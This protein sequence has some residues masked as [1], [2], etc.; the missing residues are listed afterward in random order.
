MISKRWKTISNTG[1]T[2]NIQ[3]M[4]KMLSDFRAF[5]QNDSCRLTDFWNQYWNQQSEE[6]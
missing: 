3:F 1:A 6:K 4:D 2:G 5:C